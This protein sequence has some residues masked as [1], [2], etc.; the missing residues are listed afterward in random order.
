VR[1]GGAACRTGNFIEI[2]QTEP[3]RRY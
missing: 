3:M 1:Y 2:H